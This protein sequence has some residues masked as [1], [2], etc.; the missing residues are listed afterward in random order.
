MRKTPHAVLLLDEIEKAHSDIQSILLQIMDYATI[1]DNAGKKADF[2]NVVL[3]MTSNAGAREI[4]KPV[5]GFGERTVTSDIVGDAIE[6]IFAPEFRGRLDKVVLFEPLSLEV[7][8]EIV[9]KEI[10]EFSEQLAEKHVRLEIT[11]ECVELLASQGY[12]ENSGA[13]NVARVID[14]SVKSWFV[15]EVLFGRL[16]RGG[17]AVADVGPKGTI[18]IRARA[19]RRTKRPAPAHP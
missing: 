14:D 6:R 1:T 11:D 10:R 19:K 3:I 18:V 13:R 7:V 17:K 5:M 4:G 8:K 15:D 16:S 12:S 2:R 9:R